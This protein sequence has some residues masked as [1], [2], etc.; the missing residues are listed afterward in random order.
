MLDFYKPTPKNTGTAC[1]WKFSLKDGSLYCSMIK[2]ASWDSNKRTGSFEANKKKPEATVFMKFTL[3][4]AG[5]I[6]DLLDRNR[7]FKTVHK[8][9]KQTLTINF[10]PYMRNDKQIGFSYSIFKKAEDVEVG[11]L[12]GFSFA[13]GRALREL[14]VSYL[15]NYFR[16][17][18][19]ED[20]QRRE[21]YYRRKTAA[22]E[23][24]TPAGTTAPEPETSLA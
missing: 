18:A 16:C 1:N 12:I 17:K 21:A 15:Q 19:E 4:E 14:I 20:D 11:F 23:F 5:A 13:E 6:L 7:E 2:Q 8:T 22:S 3:A 9:D 10:I 24:T